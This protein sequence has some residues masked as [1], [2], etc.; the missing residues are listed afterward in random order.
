M[1]PAGG[2]SGLA[3]AG[4]GTPSFW[5]RQRA[6]VFLLRRMVARDVS[7]RFAGTAVGMVWFLLQPLVMLGLYTLVFQHIYRVGQVEGRYGFATFTF[8][9]LWPWMSF[10]EGTMR[11]V[12]AVVDNA[13]VVK[14]L[15]FPSELFVV[16]VVVSSAIT[17]GV[18]LALFIAIFVLAGDPARLAGLPL[19]AVPIL[20]QLALAI[21]LGMLLACG[22]VFARDVA[23]IAAPALT[24]WFFLT[25]VLYA[26]SMVP[27]GLRPV[28]EWNPLT[29]I[30]RLYRAAILGADPGGVG[31]PLYSALVAVVLL[32]AG[33]RAFARCRPFF[34]DYL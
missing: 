25:P 15:R 5:S 7:V 8:C 24:V 3:A 32:V 2:R 10:Q 16:S 20:L 6:H 12:T 1:V 27:G 21:G 29:S 30:V 33:Y 18:G 13:G 28:L 34:A 11:A 26:E 23:Q 31:G 17:H 22:H 19:L 4:G 9:A 14:R